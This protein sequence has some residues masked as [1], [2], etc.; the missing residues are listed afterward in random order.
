M[1][2]NYK[3]CLILIY[4]NRDSLSLFYKQK[5]APYRTLRLHELQ[6]LAQLAQIIN[7]D[8]RRGLEQ[9]SE[10][11]QEIGTCPLIENEVTL[12]W[13]QSWVWGVVILCPK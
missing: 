6:E 5:Q 1:T 11:V 7:D 13:A 4:K 9:E 2:P 8:L 12:I 10:D 3:C